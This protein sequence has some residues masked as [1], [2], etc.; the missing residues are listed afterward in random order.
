MFNFLPDPKYKQR[1]EELWVLLDGADYPRIPN[2]AEEM[3][4]KLIYASLPHYQRWEFLEQIRFYPRTITMNNYSQS[5]TR[6]LYVGL[7]MFTI[8]RLLLN[9]SCPRAILELETRSLSQ[10]DK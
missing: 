9:L 5:E 3:M 4:P 6:L 1:L 8:S 7:S 10:A 2:W